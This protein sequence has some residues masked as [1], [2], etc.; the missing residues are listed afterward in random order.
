MRCWLYIIVCD[1]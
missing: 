1:F